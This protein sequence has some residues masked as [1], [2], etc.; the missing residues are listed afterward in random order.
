MPEMPEVE[1]IRRSLAPNLENKQIVDMDI[2]LPRQIKWPDTEEFHSML[3]GRMIKKMNRRGKYLLLELDNGNL[4]VIHLRMTGQ[5]L[6]R[7]NLDT[8]DGHS[9]L[10][11]HLSDGSRLVYAD[12]R[13]LGTIYALKQDEIWRVSGLCSLGP[14]PLSEDFTPEYLASTLEKCRAVLKSFL[15]N[16]KYIGGLGNIYADEALAEACLH[17]LKRACDVNGQEVQRLYT[18]INRVIA[19]GIADGGTTFRDYRDGNGQRGR[20][21]EQLLVYGRTGCPCKR[22]QSPVQKIQVGGRGTHFCPSCQVL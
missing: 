17:P 22:C 3:V 18:A 19:A 9:R 4:L 16:Q 6:Y 11:F 14:E 13:T 10:I 15:L 21:Q 12:T 7:E 5:L 1:M 2:L 20:H 8:Q